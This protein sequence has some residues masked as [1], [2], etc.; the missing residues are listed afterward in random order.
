MRDPCATFEY[1]ALGRGVLVFRFG[2]SARRLL[3]WKHREPETE[4]VEEYLSLP[5][6]VGRLRPSR[7]CVVPRLRIRVLMIESAMT[8]K[9]VIIPS[10][11]YT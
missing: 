6:S 9:A 1:K 7:V 10:M 2:R 8:A 11:Q 4:Q 3:S 5:S